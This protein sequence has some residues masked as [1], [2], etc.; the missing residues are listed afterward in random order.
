MASAARDC[1]ELEQENA[2]HSVPSANSEQAPGPHRLEQRIDPA[3]QAA[4][5]RLEVRHTRLD[6]SL[7]AAPL[8]N[9]TL[10]AGFL[11]MHKYEITD[12]PNEGL[13]LPFTADYSGNLAATLVFPF[14]DGMIYWRTDYIYMDDHSTNVAAQDDLRDS[15]FDDRNLLNS[16]LGWRN[17]NWDL[18]VWGKNLTDDEYASQTASPFL[19]SGMD[20]YFLAP[21]LTYGATVRYDF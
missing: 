21:P 7:E 6:L 10:S 17:D 12:G 13:E 3:V 1:L 16:K 2:R 9:L 20:A 5:Q 4:G 8:P 18:S 15:D 14:G 11:Y 19:I